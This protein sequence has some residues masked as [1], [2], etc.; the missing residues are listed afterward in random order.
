MFSVVRHYNGV[1]LFLPFQLLAS[2]SI[3]V[4]RLSLLFY[5]MTA[6]PFCLL[7]CV[8]FFQIIIINIPADIR[9]PVQKTNPAPTYI[10]NSLYFFLSISKRDFCSFLPPANKP[11]SARS[12]RC[13]SAGNLL[14]CGC[15]PVLAFFKH[16]MNAISGLLRSP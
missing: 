2:I 11:S 7:L 6:F 13:V 16:K 9:T 3:S 4:S 8:I 5:F 1:F 14:T 12:S 15:F 10:L